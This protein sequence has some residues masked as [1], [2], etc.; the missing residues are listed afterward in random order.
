MHWP[1]AHI[2]GKSSREVRAETWKAMEELYDKGRM[3]VIMEEG[4]YYFMISYFAK[5][6]QNRWGKIGTDAVW[7]GQ[8]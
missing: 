3:T 8:E 7:W 5:N 6:A 2:P 1:D 4:F